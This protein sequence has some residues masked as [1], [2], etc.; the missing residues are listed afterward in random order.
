MTTGSSATTPSCRRPTATPRPSG[1]WS[2]RWSPRRSPRREDTSAVSASRRRARS[3][4]RRAPSARSTSLQ[5]Q[6][7][8]IVERVTALVGRAGAA[9]RRRAVHGAG[10][11]V[12]WRGPRRA[13]HARHGG[14]DGRRRRAG[15]RRRAL[16][17][18]HRQCR[19]RRPRRRRTRRSAVHVRRPR[20]R[21]D[22]CV[23]PEHGAMGPRER[24]GRAAGGRRQGA[25][26]RR[27]RRGPGGAA[28]R[29]GA[30]RRRSRR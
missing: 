9:G 10:R 2:T 26:R 24:L 28:R 23:G 18:P 11:A 5:W 6:R 1:R 12:A 14:V 7:F 4:C 16:R 21:G 19:A 22:D 27:K 25:R 30:V 8:P 13:F 3:I 15:A 29:S 17:R 20:L